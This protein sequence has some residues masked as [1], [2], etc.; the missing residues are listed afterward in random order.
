MKLIETLGA[1]SRIWQIFVAD[2]S[3]TTGAGL[4]GLVF[5]SGSLVCYYHRDTDTTATAVSLVTMTVGTFTSS[6]FK[7]ID[8]TN[9]PGWY[10]LCPPNAALASGAKSVGFHLKGATNMA[11]LPI[12]VELSGFDLTL[13]TQPANVTQYGGVNGTFASGRPEVN[14]THIKGTASAGAAGYTA[15][16]LSVITIYAAGPYA[17][18]GIIDSGTAQSATGT[19]LVLR[20]AAAFADSELVGATLVIRSA[21]TGAGQ[22]RLITANVGSSDT[23]TVDTWNTTPTGTIVYDIYGTAPGSTTSPAPADLRTILG[24]AVSTPATAGILDVNVKNMNNVAGTS[25]TTVNANQ[26]TTQPLNFTGTAGSALV[27]SD[28][29]DIAGAAVSTST[30]Q[31]GVNAVQAG[32]TAWGSGAITAASIAAAALTA[33]KFAADT[34]MVPLRSGTAQAGAATTI[35]LDAS[36]SA[37]NSFYNNDLIVITGGTGAN[38][39]RFISAYVGATKVATVATWATNPDNTSTFAILPFDAVAGATAPTVAQIATGVWQDTT[40]GDFTVA[41]SIGKSLYT[42]G[43]A[44]G[45]ASG[46]ALVGSNVGAATS[47]TGAVGSVTGGVGG[48]VASVTGAVGSVTGNVGGSVASLAGSAGI[49]KNTAKAA[50]MFAMTDSTNHLPAT[51]LTVTATRSLD[52]AAFASCANAVTEV[53]AGW[54][55]ISLA[56]TDLNGDTVALK[57]TAT[58]ADQLNISIVTGP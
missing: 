1:T 49:K 32:G 18:A 34:G 36:A 4:T 43:N 46:L 41:S 38:Q 40:A 7:E 48:S 9:M 44:P 15:P 19:T 3:S 54:Y 50:F 20:S 47:V 22:R 10:Q 37:T 30:A 45:A 55:K 57:F 16:D 58:G 28:I 11:P 33:A 2:S 27:K 25:I 21:T 53:S 8:A 31:L 51:G 26:G 6:G 35:T 56:T 12:E 17:P 23:V 24:T 42:T 39:A 14:T 13:A 5:N 52:G 29:V